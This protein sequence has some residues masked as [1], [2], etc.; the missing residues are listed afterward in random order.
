[1]V[2]LQGL[3]QRDVVGNTCKLGPGI[4]RGALWVGFSYSR[5]PHDGPAFWQLGEHH[6]NVMWFDTGEPG[7]HKN[8]MG[9]RGVL[10]VLVEILCVCMYFQIFI[11]CIYKWCMY[12]CTVFSMNPPWKIFKKQGNRDPHS[13]CTCPSQTHL[14]MLGGISKG[15]KRHHCLWNY[16]VRVSQKFLSSSWLWKVKF[17]LGIW[18]KN[19]ML[20]Q[21]PC[22]PGKVDRHGPERHTIWVK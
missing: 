19:G 14:D 8:S 5:W 1:M 3:N 6:D 18:L 17:Q 21:Q 20:P 12:M 7:D 16:A 2:L 4:P 15:I 10:Q 13:P 9:S 22:L 11:F